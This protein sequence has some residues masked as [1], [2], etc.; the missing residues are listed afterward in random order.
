M[1]ANAF[2]AIELQIFIRFTIFNY[3]TGYIDVIEFCHFAM[4]DVYLVHMYLF[5]FG[6]GI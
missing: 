2:V 5:I 3:N 4:F 6:R 1:I